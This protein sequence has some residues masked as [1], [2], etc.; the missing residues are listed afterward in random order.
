MLPGKGQNLGGRGRPPAGTICHRLRD[1]IGERWLSRVGALGCS[2]TSCP[3]GA[4]GRELR[5]RELDRLVVLIA[6]PQGERPEPEITFTSPLKV[7]LT[8]VILPWDVEDK[9]RCR[10]CSVSCCFLGEGGQHL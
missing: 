9:G 8:L 7:I 4:T 10:G 3:Q 2:L 1:C 6:L 5:G